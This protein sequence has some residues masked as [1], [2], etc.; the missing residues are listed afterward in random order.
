MLSFNINVA[1]TLFIESYI[2]YMCNELMY[3]D[4]STAGMS[5]TFCQIFILYNLN[6]LDIQTPPT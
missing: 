4:A 1:L 3:D 5:F 6:N 2:W